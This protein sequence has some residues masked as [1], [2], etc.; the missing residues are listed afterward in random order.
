MKEEST[1]T[2]NTKGLDQLVKAFSGKLPTLKVGILADNSRSGPG[3]SSPTNV[4]V[5]AAHEYGAPARGIPMR[6]F[7]RMPLNDRLGKYMEEAGLFKEKVISG[8]IKTG[9]IDSYMRLTGEVAL[10]VVRDAFDSGGFGK[11]AKW[12]HPEERQANSNAGMLLVDTHQLRDSIAF[13]V[14]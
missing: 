6:S 7:L 9:S 14:K 13:E 5:G 3:K 11:W 4:Q 8:M 12:K 1:V 2:V 10:N